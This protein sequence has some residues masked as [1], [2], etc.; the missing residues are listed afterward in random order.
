MKSSD[1]AKRDDPAFFVE[2]LYGPDNTAA[3][4]YIGALRKPGRFYVTDVSKLPR[5][6]P[7]VQ[8]FVWFLNEMRGQRDVLGR[9]LEFWHEGRCCCCGRALT[10]PSSVENGIGPECSGRRMER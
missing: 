10:V 7:C 5:T 2:V 6:S 1:P 4:K 3:Y 8:A 9:V